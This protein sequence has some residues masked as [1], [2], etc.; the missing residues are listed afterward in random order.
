MAGLGGFLPPVVMEVLVNAQEAIASLGEVNAELAVLGA[1]AE[2]T[3]AKLTTMEKAGAV[4]SGAFKIMS[5]AA[6]AFGAIAVEEA[7]KAE[8]SY[9]RLNTALKNSGNGS[10]ETAE[11]MKKLAESNTKLGFTTDATAGALGTLITATHNT[12]DAQKLLNTAM[13]LARYK[14][15]DL[16]TAATVLARGTQG[17]AKA[18]K[19]MGITLDTTLP[20]QDAINKAM[21]Q[22]NEKLSGQNQAYLKTFAGQMSSL[23]AQFQLTAEKVGGM[24]IPILTKLLSFIEKNG[25]VILIVIGLFATFVLAI[26]AYEVALIAVNA[27]QK[28]Q[29]ALALASAEGIGAVKAAQLLLNDAMR[30][31]LFG[32]IATAVIALIAVMVNLYQ[33]NMKVRN[34]ILDVGIY[35]IKALADLIHW[36]GVFAETVL[37]VESGPLRLLLKGL[38]IIHAPGA[39][40]GL[41]ELNK[42]IESVGDFFDKAAKSVENYT[43][44]LE[45]MKRATSTAGT[46]TTGGGTSGTGDTTPFDLTNYA[47]ATKLTAAQKANQA[48]ID[49]AK[50]L[51]DEIST[52]VTKYNDAVTAAR[53]KAADDI[54]QAQE[55]FNTKMGEL[56]DAYAQKQSDIESNH[57]ESLAQ[58][59]QTY[60]DKVT[61]I[62]QTAADKTTAL[63]KNHAETL[64]KIEQDHI[65]KMVDI[66]LSYTEKLKGIIQKSIDEMVGAFKTAT[67]VDVGSIFADLQKAGDA[68]AD[69]LITSLTGKLTSAK[70]LAQDAADLSAKGFSQS[71]IDQVISQGPEIGDQMSQAILTSTPD[72]IKQMQDLYNQLDNVSNNGV[73]QL[74]TTMNDGIHFANQQLQEEYIQ[75]QKDLQVSLAKQNE[76]YQEALKQ[77]QTNFASATALINQT[78]NED[79]AKALRTLNE[80]TVKENKAYQDALTKA[81]SDYD[82]AMAKLEKTRDAAIK[83]ANDD[84]QKA[85]DDA[86]KTLSDALAKIQKEFESKL[87]GI[88]SS[89][90]EVTSAIGAMIAALAA[91]QAMAATQITIPTY[92]SSGSVSTTSS[93]GMGGGGST[94][95]TYSG[96]IINIPVSVGGSNATPAQIQ[97]AVVDG[98]KYGAPLGSYVV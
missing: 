38:S 49:E 46:Q 16:G 71:F 64:Q 89:V 73:T 44:K 94:S 10:K 19:E 9:A 37:K 66:Q 54:A 52:A 70:K 4:A 17:S 87:G 27:V 72:Q 22:L 95:S 61:D 92:S 85:L 74:A 51:Q 34:A 2:A 23:S 80:A 15:I 75:T 1:R 86:Q 24:L 78:Q 43:I 96:S 30:A 25:K 90:A 6:L 28:I 45:Q 11:E 81:Q 91:A 31:N 42:G 68:S 29:I 33:H 7:V 77:E 69:A 48:A 57:K 5:V 41:D 8:E 21:T 88:A 59:Q 83:K 62:N 13:D 35:G 47:G 76:A 84:L 93:T 39:K 36:F 55:T 18:F 79:L 20:K 98:I 50:K 65:S 53:T 82:D 3:G 63:N 97:A 26:K 58:I 12:E 32:I 60:N 14:H 40:A 67:S 56:N